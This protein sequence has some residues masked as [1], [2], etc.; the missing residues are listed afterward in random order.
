MRWMVCS[1]PQNG[2]GKSAK[3]WENS[4]TKAKALCP[5]ELKD[6]KRQ[7][8][9]GRPICWAYILKRGG[10]EEPVADGRC[11][12]GRIFALDARFPVVAWLPAESIPKK[13][14][15]VQQV[16]H[17]CVNSC[18]AT[19]WRAAQCMSNMFKSIVERNLNCRR[20]RSKLRTTQNTQVSQ[21]GRP[22]HT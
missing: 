19:M 21:E 8:D 10:C 7:D 16:F 1:Q 3:R 14:P 2:T 9:Q 17:R 18:Q 11:K 20:P 13:W 5:P 22:W 12:K 6:C 15:R 4:L